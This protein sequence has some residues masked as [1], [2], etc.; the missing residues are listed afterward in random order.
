MVQGPSAGAFLLSEAG[1]DWVTRDE[2]PQ[3]MLALVTC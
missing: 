1:A 2:L 3:R